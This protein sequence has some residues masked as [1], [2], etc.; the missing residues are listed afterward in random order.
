MLIDPKTISPDQAKNY[1][2]FGDV[3][4]NRLGKQCQYS[5]RLVDGQFRNEYPDLA[6]DPKYGAPLRIVGELGDYHDYRIHKDDVEELVKRFKDYLDERDSDSQCDTRIRP[7]FMRHKDY[8]DER[9]SDDDSSSG[10]LSSILE[11]D[12]WKFLK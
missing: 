7:G 8:L 4:R 5:S 10:M 2:A 12:L 1:V 6:S 3:S 11:V 9:D